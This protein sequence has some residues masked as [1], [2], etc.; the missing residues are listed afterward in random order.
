VIGKRQGNI[1][2]LT[3]Q[4]KV[5]FVGL[6]RAEDMA[7]PDLWHRRI[8]H[9][10]GSIQSIARIKN[11]VSG[12]QLSA[13]EDREISVCETCVEGKP[14]RDA[15]SGEQR[16]TE[17]ILDR[18]HSDR[19]GPMATVGLMG[20]R[21][22]ATFIDESSGRMAISPLTQK[23]QVFDRFVKYRM[24]VEKETGRKIKSL[25]SDGG[26]EYTGNIFRKYVTD[27]RITHH[28][29]PPYTPGH[30]GIAERANQTIMDMVRCMLFDAGLGKE[31]W[32]HVAL[33]TVHIIN[34]I[35]SSAH[36]YKTLYEIWFGSQPPIGHLRIFGGT[37]YGHIPSANR[38][39]LDQRAQKCRMIGYVEDSGSRVYRLY[40]AATRQVLVSR[41]EIFDETQKAGKYRNGSNTDSKTGHPALFA[42]T[43]EAEP[44]SF[45]MVEEDNYLPSV[46][47]PE[48]DDTAEPLPLI[49]PAEPNPAAQ[50]YDQDTIIVR[51]PTLPGAW[52]A[53]P[54]PIPQEDSAQ[55]PPGRRRGQREMLRNNAG[56]AL[57][58]VAEEPMTLQEALA[59]E[60]AGSWKQAWES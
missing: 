6:T 28:I 44:G 11:S 5:V 52:C 45:S 40:D 16:K 38:R 1:Y 59:G 37:V 50:S 57:I 8:G 33:T 25:R 43:T 10:S 17:Q 4:P 2:F 34:R 9:R 3:A 23:S 31:F 56:Y 12:F 7:I 51:P 21:Y 15:L 35:P 24:K 18:I 22:F 13:K 30:N 60:D 32:G 49:D 54:T 26:G 46:P 36:N 29:T 55:Q 42:D 27:S 41:D 19:C 20:E 14:S 47:L 48:G 53:T 58:A 39:K